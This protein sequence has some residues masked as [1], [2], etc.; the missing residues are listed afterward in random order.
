MTSRDISI[1]TDRA[2]QIQEREWQQ[3]TGRELQRIIAKQLCHD[4]YR[5]FRYWVQYYD[6]TQYHWT[7]GQKNERVEKHVREAIIQ[8]R[9]DNAVHAT[10]IALGQFVLDFDILM[11]ER[12]RVVLEHISNLYMEQLLHGKAEILMHAPNS[13]Y[14]LSNEGVWDKHVQR[15]QRYISLE[16]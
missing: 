16:S 11:K 2:L 14:Y 3:T 4:M 5:A 15:I 6:S 1:L 8:W 13:P 10:P 12:D 9:R 7:R